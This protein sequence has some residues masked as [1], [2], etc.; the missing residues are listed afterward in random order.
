MYCVVAGLR[1]LFFNWSVGS[2]LLQIRWTHRRVTQKRQPTYWTL[3]QKLALLLKFIL[4]LYTYSVP[5]SPARGLATR[6]HGRTL[7]P[8]PRIDQPY[9]WTLTSRIL[10]TLAISTLLKNPN[11]LSDQSFLSTKFVSH[12]AILQHQGANFIDDSP[13]SLAISFKYYFN[14]D[15]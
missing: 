13:T 8:C 15:R 4:P 7:M 3:A 6:S 10:P 9:P 2:C 12:V 1:I 14:P 5:Y 11:Y